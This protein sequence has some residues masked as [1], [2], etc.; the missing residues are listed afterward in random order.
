MLSFLKT[1]LL[2]E[3]YTDRG[4][5]LSMSLSTK[6]NYFPVFIFVVHMYIVKAEIKEL[7]QS[8]FLQKHPV[9]GK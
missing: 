1:N 4:T 5:P 2:I 7:E 3:W 6:K 8:G 9:S